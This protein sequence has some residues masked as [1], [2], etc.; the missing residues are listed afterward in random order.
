ML[1]T[2]LDQ[3]Q[4]QQ[5]I[6]TA[7]AADV[8]RQWARMGDDFDESWQRVKPRVLSTLESARSEAVA[9][10]L[11]YTAAVLAETG[12]VDDA[13]GVLAPAAF[14]SSAPDGRSM[15]TLMDEAV[16]RAKTAVGRGLT[17]VQALQESRRWLTMTSLTVLADTRREV[18]AADI[19]QRPTLTGY[20]RM[21]NPPSCR[22]CIILAGRWYRWNAGFQRHPRCFP[23]GVVVSGPS[24]EGAT[25]RWYDGEIVIL[26]TA[27]GQELPVTGNHPILTRRG[28]VPANLIQEGDYVVRSTRPEGATSIAVPDHDQ[29]PASIEDVW[30][31]LSM[32]GLA[33][34][35]SSPEDFHG[36]GQYGEV[37]VVRTD[38]SFDD[39]IEAALAQHRQEHFLAATAGTPL[40]FNGQRAAQLLDGRD[41]TSAGRGVGGL[42]LS[43][44]LGG[45]EGLVSDL[46]GFAHAASLYAGLYE[47]SRDGASGDAV[48][49]GQSVLGGAFGV[50]PDDGFGG[51]DLLSPRWD[52]PG[53]SLTVET[54]DGYASVGRDLLERL[55][56]QVELDRVV[57]ARSVQWSG[58]VYSLNS[59]EGWHVA[60]SLIVSNCDCMHVPGAENVV[61]DQRTDPY[62]TFNAMSPEQQEKVFGRSEARAIREGADIYRVV[63]VSQR[64]LATAAGA[65]RYGAPARLTV[66]DI[67]RRAGTRTN[68]IR[69]L[70]EEG[71]ILDRGQQVIARAP[72][73]RTDAQIIAAGRGRGVARIG[74]QT[75]TTARAAR[76]DAA[77]SGQRDPLA[78]ATMTAAERR[79]YDAN[80]RLQY[81][82]R[83]GNVPRGVGL[84]SADIN[85]APIAATPERIAELRRTLAREVAALQDRGTPE[86]V[87]RL[88]RLL[89]L[90]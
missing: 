16:I 44:S 87:R 21:L 45:R 42:D 19:V 22:R 73:V 57:K 63:N 8:S 7:A 12:Q 35:K 78:R 61:G 52:A 14:L 66:D 65:R 77:A 84:S 5:A 43:A 20:V 15:S 31:A 81:A 11:G 55:T 67:Y 51:K 54:A 64:G 30:D 26:T 79:L 83:T 1:R 71:F 90:L 23:A 56:G 76:F 60:N 6:S 4:Q 82:L 38:G 74:G 40:L 3:Y 72:G 29:V 80:Y 47:D 59:S 27:S 39:G 70:R 32:R 62:A 49:A 18:Y 48:L 2:A 28:W 50:L 25:R 53:D 9:T 86:S 58:H 33:R 36:D 34:V 89:G 13:V 17:A 24:T 10:A 69:M 75:V 85:A 46:P 68:A 41:A 88:A 37:D